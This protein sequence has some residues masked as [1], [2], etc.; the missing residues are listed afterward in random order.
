M[1]VVDMI[2]QVLLKDKKWVTYLGI[3]MEVFTNHI[4][5][6]LGLLYEKLRIFIHL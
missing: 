2:V 3:F 6:S 4:E 1:Q 5:L